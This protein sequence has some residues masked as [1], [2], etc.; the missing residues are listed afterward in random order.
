MEMEFVIQPAYANVSFQRVRHPRCHEL[1][2]V[3]AEHE[4]M[5]KNLSGA[6]KIVLL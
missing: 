3:V 4:I 1:V 6:R 5:V 2:V